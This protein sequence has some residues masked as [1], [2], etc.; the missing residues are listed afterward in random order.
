MKRWRQLWAEMPAELCPEAGDINA[1][2][3]AQMMIADPADTMESQM[4]RER[5]WRQVQAVWRV[6][7]RRHRRALA[8]TLRPRC[9][10]LH[11]RCEYLA[12]RATALLRRAIKTP[13]RC[14]L[15]GGGDEC[16]AWQR[17]QKYDAHCRQYVVGTW[18]ATRKL[19]C[20][21]L[22]ETEPG[23]YQVVQRAIVPQEPKIQRR[24]IW[25]SAAEIPRRNRTSASGASKT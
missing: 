10:R 20:G 25:E 16:E 5:L 18:L 14:Q 22:E 11:P 23:V 24:S 21:K 13:K 4:D 6:L 12:N 2:D 8:L 15:W 1:A 3:Y 17:W 19:S 9:R 7:S